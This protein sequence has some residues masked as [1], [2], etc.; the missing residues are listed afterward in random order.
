MS[1]TLVMSILV[2]SSHA[3][4][5]RPLQV[6]T[7]WCFRYYT[8][9]SEHVEMQEGY[10]K[11]SPCMPSESGIYEGAVAGRSWKCAVK[12]RETRKTSKRSASR[13][14]AA[15][16]RASWQSLTRR[17]A[18]VELQVRSPEHFC[19]SAWLSLGRPGGMLKRRVPASSR[20]FFLELRPRRMTII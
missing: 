11:C 7:S 15:P 12:K 4:W 18:W 14:L 16:S 9:S 6:R 10:A 3:G 13:R 5:C 8:P 2:R 17:G 1:G 19:A 20:L